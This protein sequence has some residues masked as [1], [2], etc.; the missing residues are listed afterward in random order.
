MKVK[1]SKLWN[2][3]KALGALN[4]IKDLPIKTS[5]WIGKNTKKIS[6]EVTEIE[7]KRK[8][9]VK[10]YGVENDKK[11]TSVPQ[12]KMEEFSKEFYDLLDTEIDVDLRIFNIDEFTGKSGLTGQDML[13]IDF[14][15]E[16]VKETET[17]N[18][19]KNIYPIKPIKKPKK[20]VK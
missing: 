15:F 18:V 19:Q 16:E 1:L 12:E 6:R 13:Q 14:L 3:Q 7:E 2:S 9:L 8:E 5:Y 4:V 11:E 20:E 10:K 17:E